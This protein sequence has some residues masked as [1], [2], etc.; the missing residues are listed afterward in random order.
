MESAKILRPPSLFEEQKSNSKYQWNN[1]VYS[2]IRAYDTNNARERLLE[3][4]N[5]V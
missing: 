2:F 1:E 5:L 4:S 3:L